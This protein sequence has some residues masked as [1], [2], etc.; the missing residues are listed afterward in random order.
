MAKIINRA[1]LNVGVELIIDEVARTIK[2]VATGNLTAKDGVTYQAVYSKLVDLWATST[3]QDSPFPMNAIDALSGQYL[4]GVDAGGNYNGWKWFDDTTRQMVRDGAN[5]EYDG[6]G[7]LLS[8]YS[9]IVGL[10][11]VNAGS[12]LYFQRDSA[13][14]PTDFT[15]E[16][17]CNEMIQV[18]G[19]TSN[20]N[21]DKRTYFKAFVREQGKKYKDSV[22]ADTGK[23]ATG[24]YIVNMLLSN[25]DDLKISDLDA[26]MSNAPYDNISVEYFAAD[27]VRSI[28]GVDYDFDVIV[29]GNNAT[30]EQIYTKLQYLLRQST[31]IDSG[32]GTVIG[33]T[34]SLLA[35]FVGNN[36]ET[37]TGV[38]IDNI[39][40]AD[41]N[42]ISFKDTSGTFRLNPFTASGSL[43]FNP[44]M[45]GAGS[46]YRLMY[47]AVT[48]ADN[49]YG[50]SGAITVV[51]AAGN[52][53]TGVITAGSIDFTFDYD[54]D[55]VGGPAGSEKA[56]TLIGIRPN[57][58]KFAVAE[59]ILTK[60]KAITLGLTAEQDRAYL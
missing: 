9:S 56:V 35:G 28:G 2:L 42:R 24:A 13:D 41:S 46:S 55:A 47:T 51:D 18:F 1:D 7:N 32:A 50:E 11:A 58:S 6:S 25:E 52:P 23:S 26:E 59:G 27:Q 17:Q 4:I 39:Q 10:G 5:E 57:S 48:G 43:T 22:L 20:G 40:N 14:A 36:L 54:G 37:T 38:F 21:F 15:F 3:Y 12:Q 16:D 29:E 31:D 45:V 30:L 33:Q 49:D 34:A 19:D 60:S 53:I 8:V 44:I